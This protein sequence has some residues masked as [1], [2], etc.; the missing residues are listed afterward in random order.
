MT[1][2]AL[3]CIHISFHAC[4]HTQ[5]DGLP[6]PSDMTWE[7]ATKILSNVDITRNPDKILENRPSITPR[8]DILADVDIFFSNVTE[9]D[10]IV[11]VVQFLLAV[12]KDIYDSTG[13]KVQIQCQPTFEIHPILTGSLICMTD[14]KPKLIIEVK[15]V[16]VYTSLAIQTKEVAE[17]LRE[18]HILTEE[19]STLPFLLTNSVIWSFGV[20]QRVGNKVTVLSTLEAN[21]RVDYDTIYQVLRKYLMPDHDD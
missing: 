16:A 4:M 21:V 19:T 11:R 3:H 2:I 5:Q 12:C 9:M 13:Q 17:I 1:I 15:E 14:G 8:K 18:V 20:A 10:A 7:D 6:S